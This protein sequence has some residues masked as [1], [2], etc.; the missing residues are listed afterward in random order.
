MFL[1]LFLYCVLLL[2]IKLMLW[3]V[4]EV[5]HFQQVFFTECTDVSFVAGEDVEFTVHKESVSKV[6]SAVVPQSK[7]TV[8]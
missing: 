2:F 8:M 7:S 4:V 6:S 5:V 3:Y 1:Y